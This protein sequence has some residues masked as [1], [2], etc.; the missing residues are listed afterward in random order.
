MADCRRPEVDRDLIFGQKVG[1][2]NVVLE[3]KFGDPSSNRLGAIQIA[4]FVTTATTTA[5]RPI[6]LR[7][8]QLRWLGRKKI[9]WLSMTSLATRTVIFTDNFTFAFVVPYRKFG[10]LGLWRNG[11]DTLYVLVW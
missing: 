10:D 4:H 7:P 6:P 1:R 2:V 9:D 11:L 5:A 3:T 8:N